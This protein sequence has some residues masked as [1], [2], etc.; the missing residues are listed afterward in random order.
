M[1]MQ[2]TD[3]D[4]INLSVPNGKTTTD[5]DS[6]NP[7]KRNLPNGKDDISITPSYTSQNE[8]KLSF[9]KRI[10]VNRALMVDVISRFLFPL[11]YIFFNCFYWAY[12]ERTNSH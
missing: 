6:P 2:E 12:Y 10:Q 5:S 8:K 11:L 4:K 9:F 7:R 1:E 3:I